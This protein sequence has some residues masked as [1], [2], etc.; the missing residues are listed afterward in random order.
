MSYKTQ[1][2]GLQRVYLNN[3]NPRHDPIDDEPQII[4]YLLGKEQV[5][6]LAKD[7]AKLG[8][9]PLERLGVMPHPVAADSFVALEGNRRLCA[10]KL[11]SDPDKAP[12]EATSKIY[13]KLKSSMLSPPRTIEVVVFSD[14]AAARPWLERKHEGAMNGVGTRIARHDL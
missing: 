10:L 6:N 12:K 8:L 2:V 7:I 3:E 9:S 11:L 1:M 14:A 13:R 4:E 5:T